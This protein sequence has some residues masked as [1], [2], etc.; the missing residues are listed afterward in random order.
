M[1]PTSV[2]ALTFALTVL[3]V[4]VLYESL[5]GAR[6][7]NLPRRV[8]SRLNEE[9]TPVAPFR[10]TRLWRRH[11]SRLAAKPDSLEKLRGSL[12]PA[13]FGSLESV[14]IFHLLRI[15]LVLAGAVAGV[16]LCLAIARAWLI[17]ALAGALLGYLIPTY[18]LAR[19]GRIRRASIARELPDI[20]A[21][22]VVSLEAGIAVGEM[23]RLIGHETERQGRVLGR[24]LSAVAAQMS[25]G[26][27]LEDS[28][29][30]MAERTGVEELKSLVALLIQS[31]RIGAR[32]APALRA[33][34][35]LLNSRRRLAAQEA[36]HKASVKILIPLIFFILPAMMLIILG[37][38]MIQIIGMFKHGK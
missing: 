15:G 4:M 7:V 5:F 31:E 11:L 14:A 32:L 21:L 36:A 27:S 29:Q 34:A 10:L 26:R 12:A 2:A 16:A 35:A 1:S 23:I 25:A 33:S 6:N 30:H 20:L 28:L 18:V 19:M 13:G 3:S 38:A 9:K 22:M 8:A 37:P 24:E 17:G